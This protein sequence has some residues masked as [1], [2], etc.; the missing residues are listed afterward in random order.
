MDMTLENLSNT[1]H[2][3]FD[4]R[5]VELSEHVCSMRER[6]P[7]AQL[8]VGTDSQNLS[9]KTIYVTTVVFRF[10][11]NGAHVIY[12]KQRKKRINDMWSRL[13]HEMELSVEL[14]QY[15][16]ENCKVKVHQIDMDLNEDP[17]YSSNKVLKAA[18][19]FI[20]SMGFKAMAKPNILMATWAANSLCH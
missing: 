17:K 6:Y 3:M 19:G 4:Q 12:H 15:I 8:Y 7:E 20:E 16:E 9:N 14:A 1:F 18:Q 10:P 2:T 5:P 11:N 13:W